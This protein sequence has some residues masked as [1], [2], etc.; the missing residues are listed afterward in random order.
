MPRIPIKPRWKKGESGNPL[1]KKSYIT[2]LKEELGDK[3]IKEFVRN[4]KSM[5][6]DK[7]NIRIIEILTNIFFHKP[8]DE[9]VKIDGYKDAVGFNEKSEIIMGAVTDGIIT[10]AQAER[11]MNTLRNQVTIYESTTLIDKVEELSRKVNGD[12]DAD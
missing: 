6:I 11:L 1:G 12:K 2:L 9:P 4:L 8:G 5:A 10:M 7:K 3:G